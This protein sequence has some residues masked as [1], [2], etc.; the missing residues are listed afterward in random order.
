MHLT[1]RGY[2]DYGK[3]L[4]EDPKFEPHDGIKMVQVLESPFY[5]CGYQGFCVNRVCVK[6]WGS[7]VHHD[8]Y[9]DILK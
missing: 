7:T 1:K 2:F 6:D 8:L 9:P 3:N 5:I 4:I